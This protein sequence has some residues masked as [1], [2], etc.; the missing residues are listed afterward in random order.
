V[1]PSQINEVLFRERIIGGLDISHLIDNGMLLCVTEVNTRQGIDRL[2][3]T[4]GSL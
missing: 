3:K 1:P 2:V 4:L